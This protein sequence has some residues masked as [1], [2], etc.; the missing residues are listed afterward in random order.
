MFFGV[1]GV[2]FDVFSVGLRFGGIHFIESSLGEINFYRGDT[3]TQTCDKKY[4]R[5]KKCE[6]FRERKNKHTESNQK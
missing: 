4:K 6:N 1:Q 3:N 2:D 5:G